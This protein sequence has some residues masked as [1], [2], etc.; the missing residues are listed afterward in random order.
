[1]INVVNQDDFKG[2]IYFITRIDEKLR[3]LDSCIYS[4]FS[5]DT[6]QKSRAFTSL[7]SVAAVVFCPGDG[8]FDIVSR[9]LN[10]K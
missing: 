10:R 8:T 4:L 6:G 1:M 3:E 7:H 5:G 9:L 2:V